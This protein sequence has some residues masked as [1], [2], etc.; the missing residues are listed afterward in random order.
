VLHE[1]YHVVQQWGREQMSILG[2]LFR[3]GQREREA[4]EFARQ[5]LEEYRQ[6][7]RSWRRA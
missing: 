6:L 7:L 3:A 2:Y 1:F 4:D 5:N